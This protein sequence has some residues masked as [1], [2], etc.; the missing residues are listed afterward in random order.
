MNWKIVVY[1]SSCKKLTKTPIFY[2]KVC[3]SINLSHY[4]KYT[5]FGHTYQHHNL[6]F[7]LWEQIT[8]FVWSQRLSFEKNLLFSHKTFR[9]MKLSTLIEISNKI[10]I[11]RWKYKKCYLSLVRGTQVNSWA[12]ISTNH[13][14]SNWEN[15]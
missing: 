10:Q 4:L 5:T 7:V 3:F 2:I 11:D 13:N 1:F 12:Y 14:N 15:I 8:L 6:L 9:Q